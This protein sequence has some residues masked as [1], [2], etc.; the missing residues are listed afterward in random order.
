MQFL[1]AEVAED[2]QRTQ[3]NSQK[4]VED[5]ARTALGARR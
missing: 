3:R 2:S 4:V 5:F 1:N